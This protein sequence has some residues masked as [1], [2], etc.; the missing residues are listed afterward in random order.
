M[1][2]IASYGFRYRVVEAETRYEA[3]E[4]AREVLEVPEGEI[5]AVSLVESNGVR[6]GHILG[7]S[8][9]VSS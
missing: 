7:A 5:V 6:S 8:P 9:I 4:R 3:R 1:R 2:F